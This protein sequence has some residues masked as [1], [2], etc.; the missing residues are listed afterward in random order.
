MALPSRSLKPAPPDPILGLAESF[1]ADTRP[2][3]VNL[4]VGVYVDD[5]GT[6]PLIPSV[7]EAERRLLAKAGSKGYLPIDGRPG[8]KSSVRDLIFGADHEIV[9][10]GRSVTAQTPGGTGALRVAADFLIQTGS[11]K[12]IWLSDPTW[13]NHPQLFSMAGFSAKT[14]PYL[15]ASGRG[16]DVDKMLAALRTAT[17]GDVVLLHGS[18]HNPS[19]VDPDQATWA[20]IGEV[21]AER[22]LVPIVD[23]AY[24]GFGFG[25]REDADWLVGLARPG[26]EFLVCTSYSKNFA[27]YNE[28][29]GALTLVAADSDRA[30]AALSHIKIAIRANYSNPPAHGGDIVETILTDPGLRAQWEVDLAGMRNRILGNR[31]ALVDALV[32]AGVPGN[33]EPLRRQRGMFALLGLSADQVARLRDEFGVYVVS[34]GRINVAGLTAAN[35]P[36]VIA[37]V[38]AVIAG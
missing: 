26:L 37:A 17:P 18:C 8:Y 20:A 9:A 11:N 7:S 36:T 13:P 3:K 30:A 14:Y 33:W 23:F 35:M 10:S 22:E 2:H 16:L 21:V 27:L 12:T 24:Q 4:S 38:K 28:R 19:G 15:D 5:S 34:R 1:K 6:T 29:V 25:L 31:A 32:A